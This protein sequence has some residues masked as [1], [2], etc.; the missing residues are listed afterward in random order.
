MKDKALQLINQFGLRT[1][2]LI[3][4]EVYNEIY[5]LPRI[6]YNERR[7]IF[8]KGVLENLEDQEEK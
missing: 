5:D 6:P 8:W 4:K 3:A 1:A 7:T 2:K